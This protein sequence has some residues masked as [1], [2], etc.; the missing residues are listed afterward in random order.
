MKIRTFRHH[1]VHWWRE[2]DLRSQSWEHNCD[3]LDRL[4][5]EHTR[6]NQCSLLLLEIRTVTSKTRFIIDTIS[7]NL[8]SKGINIAYIQYLIRAFLDIR[9]LPFISIPSSVACWVISGTFILTNSIFI[10]DMKPSS[11]LV[12]FVKVF[13]Y[14]PK[15]SLTNQTDINQVRSRSKCRQRLK[16]RKFLNSQIENFRLVNPSD[17]ITELSGPKQIWFLIFWKWCFTST[18]CCIYRL[19]CEY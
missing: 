16:M 5:Q 19:H 10:T 12:T 8:S 1:R 11:W 9:T 14:I 2:R 6:Q 3:I 18:V 13:A 15:H 17:H 7:C 4:Q